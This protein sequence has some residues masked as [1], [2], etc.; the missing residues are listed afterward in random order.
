MQLLKL[1]AHAPGINLI[2]KRT[3]LLHCYEKEHTPY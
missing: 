3:L 2:V 1:I